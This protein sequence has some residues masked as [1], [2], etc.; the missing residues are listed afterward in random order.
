MNADASHSFQAVARATIVVLS[1][2][3]GT[4]AFAAESGLKQEGPLTIM[5][6]PQS[7]PAVGATD[8]VHAKAKELPIAN[9]SE[10]LARADLIGLLASHATATPGGPGFSPGKDGDGNTSPVFLGAPGTESG[11]YMP[12]EAG[13]SNLPF[14]TARADGATGTTN[15]IYPFRAA[16]RLFFNEGVDTFVCSASLIKK[17]IVLTAAHCVVTFGTKRFH[18]NFHFVPGYRNGVAPYGTWTAKAGFVLTSYF[19][20]TDS[21]SQTGV[22]C[23]DDMALLVLNAQNGALPGT[24]TGWYGFAWN[25]VGF[26]PNSLTH[27]TQIGYPVC[28]DNGALMERNDSQGSKSVS[29]SNNTVIGTLMCGGSSGGPWL[30]NFGQRPT[31]TGTTGGSGAE[32]NTVV[33]VTSWGSTSNAPKISGA[34]P[35]L[36][37][38]ILALVNAACGADPGNC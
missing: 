5:T 20:G 7:Q 16:G 35:F 25:G 29:N 23:K 21:C 32:V 9:Y 14:S 28:L 24:S 8:Y 4:A 3:V 30:I 1:C 22:V 15:R 2:A 33:G 34:S 31:L 37:T 10:D 11:G 18:S 27:V 6:F 12:E 19:N 36:N 13:T 38:N 17:G 26:T